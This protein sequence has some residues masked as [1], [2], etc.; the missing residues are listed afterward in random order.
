MKTYLIVRQWPVLRGFNL[1]LQAGC[2]DSNNRAEVGNP[3]FAN[4]DANSPASPPNEQYDSVRHEDEHCSENHVTTLS[5][6][7]RWRSTSR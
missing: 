6:L 3:V 5:A 4:F 2:N 1:I 7:P